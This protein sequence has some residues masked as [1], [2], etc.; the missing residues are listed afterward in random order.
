MSVTTDENQAS[1]DLIMR[2]GKKDKWFRSGDTPL[3]RQ[4]SEGIKSL[5]HTGELVDGTKLP[6]VRDLADSLNLS[7]GTVK[8]AYNSLADDGY[9]MLKQGK[10]T[11]VDLP[12]TTREPELSRKDRAMA[13]IDT[14]LE[15]METLGFSRR[16]T[17]IFI[18]LKLRERDEHLSDLQVAIFAESPEESSL[19]LNE[20]STIPGVELYAYPAEDLF[21]GRVDTSIMDVLV[22][23]EKPYFSLMKN[24]IAEY[25]EKLVLLGLTLHPQT[26]IDLSRLSPD[27]SVGILGMSKTYTGKMLEKCETYANLNQLPTVCLFQQKE[28]DA[29]L[30]ACERVIVPV[31]YLSY[32]NDEIQSLWRRYIRTGGK[33][34]Y[35]RTVC[36]KSCL[37]AIKLRLERMF[38]SR[39]DRL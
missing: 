27:E 34:L 31:D 16:E 24:P 37:L 10:G 1:L 17:Q 39:H 3:Y 25:A 29:F 33:V 7:R 2:N 15:E 8:H 26:L 14:M 4:L 5:I 21:G 18:E 11:F 36:E 32:M 19:I 30:N 23:T 35:F 9:L 12:E 22:T 6:T 13:S 38:E 28:L 20:L